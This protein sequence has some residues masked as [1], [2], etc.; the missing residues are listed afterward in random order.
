M[1]VERRAV[2]EDEC[3]AAGK[4]GDQP[5][6]HHPCCGCEIEDARAW[7]DGAVEDVLFFVLD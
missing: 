4:S 5:V 1:W 2:V 7:F 6:P 3:C